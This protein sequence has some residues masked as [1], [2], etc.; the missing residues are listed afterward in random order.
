MALTEFSRSDVQNVQH[1]SNVTFRETISRTFLKEL[2]GKGNGAYVQRLVELEKSAGDLIKYD[3]LYQMTQYGVAGD[4]PMAGFEESLVYAQDSVRVDQ[5][6]IGHAFRRMSQ[7]RTLHDLR[8]DAKDNL[9]DRWSVLMDKILFAQLTGKVGTLN[10]PLPLHVAEHGGNT[11]ADAASDAD[12]YYLTAATPVELK[13]A[14]L[15]ALVEKAQTIDPIIRPGPG[16]Y[17]LIVHPYSITDLRNDAGVTGW[18][19]IT[20]NVFSGSGERSPFA[21]WKVGKYADIEIYASRYLPMLTISAVQCSAG[22]F[23]GA[24]AGVAAFANAYDKVDQSAGMGGGMIMSWAERRDDYGNEKGVAAGAVFGFKPAI[25]GGKRFGMIRF[26]AKT[27][28]HTT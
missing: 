20:Q 21:A 4:D 27:V 11:L 19:E 6:R 1:W 15:D 5:R 14:H 12:H 9:S 22:I 10:N 2:L 28:K 8:T 7:Q 26:D 23:L 24:Q 3:I 16:G 18:R 13:L 17:K 25:F